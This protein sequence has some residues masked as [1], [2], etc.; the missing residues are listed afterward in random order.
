[1]DWSTDQY[2]Q[3]IV[4]L[5][6][7]ILLFL[8][9][10]MLPQRVVMWVLLL[11][12]P[13]QPIAS[14]YGTINILL[15]YIV[16]V[17]FLLR[18]RIRQLPLLGFVAFIMMA[19]L[20]S[21]SQILPGTAKDHGLYLIAMLANFLLFFLTY[22][23]VRSSAS[24]R[25]IW[26]LLAILNVLVLIYCGLEMSV[27]LGQ[28]HLLG[29]KELTLK[30]AR[31]AEGRLG[32]P[33]KATALTAEYLG[34]QCLICGYTLMRRSSSFPRGFWWGL[35]AGNLGIL[36]STG[37]RGGIVSLLAGFIVFLFLF[38]KELSVL[39][40]TAM[41][42]SASLVFAISAFVVVEY[43][44]YNVLFER[45]A[46]TEFEGL[47][48]DTREGWYDMWDKII[49]KPIIG[50]GPRMRLIDEDTRKVSGYV[51]FPYPHNA[52]LYL[53]YTIGL[54]GL[55]SYILF[56]SE[57]VR[58]YWRSFSNRA[59]DPLLRGIPRLGLAILALFAVSEMR[60]EMFRGY[61]TDYSQYLFML[62]GVFLA[63]SH[64]AVDTR[65]TSRGGGSGT[66]S[67]LSV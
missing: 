64:M 25:D 15:T 67:G 24:V 39:K 18:G 45:L 27:G 20:L 47:V 10:Y 41:V 8:I 22:N 12:I 2:I 48:P 1:M 13:F 5:C 51:P 19:Y 40:I 36:V 63:L 21:F 17:A 31:A 16:G 44:R 54:L 43:T 28:E 61:L 66:T 11:M 34:I 37:N 56:F 4:A 9:A 14:R 60:I 65:R 6:G 52:Y 42:V 3:L 55:F 62:V 26:N 7:G 32:G 50:H 38:R 59:E 57:L 23:Y 46:G 58:Q 29:L 30:S 53:I 33:F 35:L 49:E